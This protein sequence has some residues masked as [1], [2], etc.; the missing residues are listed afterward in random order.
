MIIIIF[1]LK[2]FQHFLLN[3]QVKE[4]KEVGW[5]EFRKRYK[6]T[7]RHVEFAVEMFRRQSQ[8]ETGALERN[9]AD[10]T[11]LGRGSK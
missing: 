7:C 4:I 11:N 8:N 2:Q 1:N 10:H 9:R 6:L 3:D 5:N